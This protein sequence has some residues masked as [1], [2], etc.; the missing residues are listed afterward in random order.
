MLN[1]QAASLKTS[2][3][4]GQVLRDPLLTPWGIATLLKG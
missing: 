1:N 3:F 2:E 4:G